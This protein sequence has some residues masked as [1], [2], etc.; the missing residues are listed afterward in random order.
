MLID[1]NDNVRYIG[2][3][4]NLQSRSTDHKIKYPNC[5]FEIIDEIPTSEWKFW[6]RHYIWLYKSWGFSIDN[7]KCYG[8]NG[9][10]IAWNIGIK[11]SDDFRKKVSLGK[12]G[13]ASSFKG[14]QHSDESK[15]KISKSGIGRISWNKGKHNIYTEETRRKISAARKG[16][17]PW[18]K[19]TGKIKLK[20]FKTKI[21]LCY[22][23]GI[24]YDSVRKAAEAKNISYSYKKSMLNGGHLNK[25]SLKYI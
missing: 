23:T 19:G 25:T 3:T 9:C 13:K 6:E 7:K 5:K 12:L 22:N 15:N 10:D 8:G 2:K 16:K 24:F 21:V 17:T 1:D 14:K 20:K 11:M 18:N 4:K